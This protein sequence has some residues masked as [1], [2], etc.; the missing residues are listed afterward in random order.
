MSRQ[1]NKLTASQVKNAKCDGKIRKLAD[2]GGLTLVVK[3]DAKYWWLRYRFGGNE[4][5]LSLGSYPEVGLADA[6]EERDSAKKLLAQGIDPSANRQLQTEQRKEDSENTFSVVAKEWYNKK[7][8]P[9]VSES[10]AVRSWR[11]LELYTFPSL[12]TR[13]INEIQPP[14]IR[15]ILDKIVKRGHLETAHRVKNVVSLVFRYAVATHKAKFDVTR[16]LTGYLPSAK[17]KHQPSLTTPSEVAKLLKDIDAYQG[18]FAASRAFKLSPLV[19]TRPG[20]IRYMQWN[21]INF[22]R[23]QWEIPKTKNGL[24]LIVPLSTQALE[25]LEGIQPITQHRSAYVFPNARDAKRPMS[26]AAIK[27]ALD[28]MGYGGRFTAHGFRAMARTLLQ[29]ELHYP[30]HLI[31]MQLGHRV[32]DMHGRAYNRTEFLTERREMMQTWADYLDNLKYHGQE[33][34]HQ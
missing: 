20:D 34:I 23:A 6:R 32:A 28:R 2:G 22:E 17:V 1:L 9:E 10:H 27:A 33:F 29:E 4:R 30:V 13:P 19:F 25:V 31:E 5:T 26:N 8:A 24:P 21:H 14:E 7:H 11:K 18:M 3:G 12:S 15:E 16:D